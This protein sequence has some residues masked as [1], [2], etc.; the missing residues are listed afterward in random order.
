MSGRIEGSRR[1]RRTGFGVLALLATL[2][3]ALPAGAAACIEDGGGSDNGPLIGAAQITPSSFSFEGGS[4]VVSGEVEDDCG[5]QQ[6]YAE[7]SSTE[8]LY[9]SIQLLPYTIINDHTTLYRGEFQVPPNYQEWSVGYQAVIQ[10]QDTNGAIEQ[11][12]A[13]EAEVAGLP[14]FDEA[15]YVSGASLSPRVIGS[16]GGKVTIGADASDNRAVT[17]AL[18]I[19]TLPDKTQQEVPLEPVSGQH[20]EGVFEAPANPS[21]TPQ[22]YSVTVYAED[23]IGQ[24]GSESAGSFTVSPPTGRLTVWPLTKRFFGPVAIGNTATRLVVVHNS[25]R[26]KTGPIKASISTSGAPFSLPG[27]GGGKIDFLLGPGKTRIFAVN[28][29]PVSS[30]LVVGSAIVSRED[31]AQPD[32]S[33]RLSGQGVERRRPKPRPHR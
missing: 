29:A 16:A 1:R 25:G 31:R 19:V 27:A 6:V 2:A 20:F 10:A 3:L 28:F 30:G 15:P 14:P 7:V 33:V 24:R 12:Y 5:I 13:G 23:D 9:L 21:A 8:G 32:I 26:P 17:A 11:A 18:A 4:A 22:E